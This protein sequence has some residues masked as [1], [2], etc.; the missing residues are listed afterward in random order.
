ML[1]ISPMARTCAVVVVVALCGLAGIAS[2]QPDGFD[3]VYATRRT[4]YVRAE[5]VR[6]FDGVRVALR[7]RAIDP[8]VLGWPVVN[9]FP[10]FLVAS[11]RSFAI[12][13]ILGCLGLCPEL[14]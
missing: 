5:P 11:P 7:R 14:P 3:E 13:P 6:I 4:Y 9:V 12:L 8:G 2:A 10:A 1:Q